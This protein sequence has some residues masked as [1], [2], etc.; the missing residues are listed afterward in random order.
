MVWLIDDGSSRAGGDLIYRYF[1]ILVCE[2]QQNTYLVWDL[3]LTQFVFEGNSAIANRTHK[4]SVVAMN[5]LVV[6]Q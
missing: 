1:S 4:R 3:D 2:M 5:Q 6:F